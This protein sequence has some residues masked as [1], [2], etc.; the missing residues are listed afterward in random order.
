MNKKLTIVLTL[1]LC[2]ISGVAIA[3]SDFL[4]QFKNDYSTL[5]VDLLN[6]D[7]ETAEIKDFVYQKDVA[8]FTFKEG[9]LF[10]LRYVNDRPTTAI[11]MGQGH[12]KIDVPVSAERKGL[13]KVSGDSLVGENFELL[14]M[15]M[16]DN[17]DLKVKE[18]YECGGK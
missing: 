12:A 9:T 7:I 15:R 11:F 10:L 13:F 16:G 4:K 3:D 2:L 14:F 8:T 17:F 1:C 6:N 18:K 5:D